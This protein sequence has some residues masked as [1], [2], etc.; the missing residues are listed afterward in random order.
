MKKQF[1]AESKRLLELMIHSIYTHSDIFL[2]ELV[3]NASDAID[4]L[5]FK[6]LKEN[7][8]LDKFQ[9]EIKVDKENRVIEIKDNG[10]G[11]NKS[12]LETNLGT[13]AK[14]DSFAFKQA[15]DTNEVDVIG[16]FGVGFYSSF[17]VGK[18]VEVISKKFGDE[19]G[20]IFKCENV[21][22]FVIEPYEVESFGT[23][24]RVYIHDNNEENYDNYLDTYYIEHLIKKYSD[25]IRYPILLEKEVNVF[26][27]QGNVKEVEIKNEVI[28][29][30]VPIWKKNKGEI[31]EEQYNQFYREK[32]L[33]HEDPLTVI[34]SNVEGNISF[35]ALLYI[36]SHLPSNYYSNEFKKGLQLYSRGVYINDNIE[37]LLPDYFR[38]VKG[39]VDS[40]DL[41]LNISLK[42]RMAT[43]YL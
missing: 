17:I 19:Q 40:Y 25:Y 31:T 24:V 10:I 35:N 11:M 5:Y 41:S 14:S 32:F 28:N 20:H 22:G 6:S 42:N 29:S 43:I 36:P 30:M 39:L 26:D 33:D 3:S 7:L 21:D 12:E 9:I 2:R 38:F 34:H 37:E 16:Q 8:N 23:T 1:K 15:N 27:E 18:K 4:K 13:I